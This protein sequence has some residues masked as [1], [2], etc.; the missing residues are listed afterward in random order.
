[1]LSIYKLNDQELSKLFEKMLKPLPRFLKS[2]IHGDFQSSEFSELGIDL[3]EFLL[4][5]VCALFESSIYF[6]PL[7]MIS[8]LYG[9]SNSARSDDTGG[10]NKVIIDYVLLDNNSPTATDSLAE[11]NPRNKTLRGFN[12]IL[13]G[14]LLCPFQSVED[15]DNNPKR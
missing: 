11:K 15:F 10:L 2:I 12:D 5:K 4:G 8:Q 14:R 1:M 7:M 9:Y 13:T 6:G 3:Q